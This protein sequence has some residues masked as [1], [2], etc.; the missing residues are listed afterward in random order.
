MGTRI[1]DLVRDIFAL[2]KPN[3]TL[4]VLITTAGGLW[5][6]PGGLSGAALFA[7]S[8]GTL[9]VVIGANALNCYLERESDKFMRR[10][11][12]RPL[13]AGR[14][15]P[16]FAL[17]VGLALA[18]LSVAALARWVKLTTTLLAALAFVSY[19]WVYTPMKRLSPIALVVGAVPGAMP[20]LMGWTA[21]RGEI[22]A[23]GLALFL[24]LFCWQMPHFIAISIYRLTD[25]EQAG[26]KTVPGTYGMQS[27]LRQSFLWSVAMVLASL[28]L[29]PLRIA[30]GIYLTIA[31]LLG[32]G[33]LWYALAGYRAPQRNRWA[34]RFFLYSL[35]YLTLLFAALLIDAGPTSPFSQEEAM[36]LSSMIP[37]AG[38]VILR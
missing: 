13:P 6:A 23:A 35:V 32:V 29:T 8:L 7:T 12:E 30:G 34:R 21:V 22:E 3:I 36:P 9:G 33:F 24:I 1:K 11:R 27:A 10:T 25:Y 28:S 37:S 4:L 18:A 17:Y 14:L 20:P 38:K 19:V 15:S 26:L 31:S 5:L 2:A 16:K